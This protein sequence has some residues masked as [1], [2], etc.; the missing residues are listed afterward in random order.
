MAEVTLSSGRMGPKKLN[1]V[2]PL[3]VPESRKRK[4]KPVYHNPNS[5]QEDLFKFF[6]QNQA[7][8]DEWFEMERG[9]ATVSI[10][11]RKL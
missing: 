5:R 1:S 4:R 10:P 8:V 3:P 9:G 7:S 2:T 11:R 6:P